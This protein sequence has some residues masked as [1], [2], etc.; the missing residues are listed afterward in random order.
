MSS[1]FAKGP[2]ADANHHMKK[3]SMPSGM[4]PFILF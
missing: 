4:L 3:G 1:L 2:F